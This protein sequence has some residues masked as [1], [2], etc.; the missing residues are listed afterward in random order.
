M[1]VKLNIKINFHQFSPS[2]VVKLVRATYKA[3]TLEKF[4]SHERDQ[5]KFEE[6]PIKQI[7]AHWDQYMS[8]LIKGKNKFFISLVRMEEVKLSAED[9]GILV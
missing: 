4:G 6:N 9:Q 5:K 3:I 7:K 8:I 1:K 2:T